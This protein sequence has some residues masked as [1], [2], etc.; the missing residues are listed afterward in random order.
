M[1]Y[2]ELK[3]ATELIKRV[4]GYDDLKVSRMTMIEFL[5]FYKLA[6]EKDNAKD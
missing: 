4:F 6:K 3:E 5:H 2:K 1:T